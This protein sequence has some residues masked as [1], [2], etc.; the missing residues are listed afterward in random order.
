VFAL[1]QTGQPVGL[2]HRAALTAVSDMALAEVHSHSFST[3]TGEARS[4][5]PI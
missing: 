4:C 1:R 5:S 3:F 2:V